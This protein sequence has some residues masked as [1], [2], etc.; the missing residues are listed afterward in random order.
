[1]LRSQSVTPCQS[2]EAVF[3]L[4][5]VRMRGKLETLPIGI[6]LVRYTDGRVRRVLR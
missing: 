3:N 4:Q 6:Y 2:V 5:G 1:M